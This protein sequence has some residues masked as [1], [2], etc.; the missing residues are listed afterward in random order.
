ML[1]QLYIE[2]IAVIERAAIDFEAGFN[3][4]TGETGAGKSIIIDAIQAIRGER[5]SKEL[6]RT[7]A[8]FAQVS[9]VFSDL[10]GSAAEKLAALVKEKYGVKEA[11]IGNLGAV[12]GSHAGPGTLALFFMGN[13]K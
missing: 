3:V 10:S 1:S 8:A 7:G 6:I 2:N 13:E 11:F 12:I 4:L 9:A 5:M